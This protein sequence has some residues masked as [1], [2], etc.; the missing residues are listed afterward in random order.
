MGLKRYVSGVKGVGDEILSFMDR[1][2]REL[3]GDLLQK[4]GAPYFLDPKSKVMAAAADFLGKP[5]SSQKRILMSLS[6]EDRVRIVILASAM[7]SYASEMMRIADDLIY[8]EGHSYRSAAETAA[9]RCLKQEITL[10]SEIVKVLRRY[11]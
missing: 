1:A 9:R 8:V 3:V 4:H 11:V 2:S 7:G 10:S 5:P 6:P